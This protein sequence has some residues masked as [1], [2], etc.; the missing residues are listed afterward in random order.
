MSKPERKL[1]FA[2]VMRL[3]YMRLMTSYRCQVC[4]GLPSGL[5]FFEGEGLRMY[6]RAFVLHDNCE[7]APYSELLD[8]KGGRE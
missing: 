3:S 7:C 6:R 8:E 1:S 4:F 2:A 5:G